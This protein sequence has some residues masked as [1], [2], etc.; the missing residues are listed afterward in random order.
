MPTAAFYTFG[1]RLNQ[2]ETAMMA[3]GLQNIGYKIITDLDTADLCVI[4]TCTVTDQSDAK[5]LQKIRS[6]KRVNSKAVIAVVGC[7]SQISE[8]KIIEQD[9][10]D[11]IIGNQEKLNLAEYVEQFLKNRLPII[12]TGPIS[13]EPFSINLIGQHLQTTRANLKIQDGCDFICSFCIIPKAR[14]RARSREMDNIRQEAMVLANM[15]V[16]EIVLTGV[17][18]GTYH[19]DGNY[20]IDL[21]EIFESIA[22]VERVRISSIEPSTIGP[23]I[24]PWMANKST[25]TLPHL[26]LPLQSTDNEILT[27]MRRKYRFEEYRD[28]IIQA[29]EQVPGICIG[30]DVIVG[31]PGETD[32][33]F[34]ETVT[35]LT[36]IPIHYFHVFPYAERK[37]TTSA[38]M[39]GAVSAETISRRAA[40]LRELSDQ[41]RSAFS[42]T[43]IGQ[44]LEVLFE[45]NN[46]GMVWKGYSENYIRISVNG[47]IPLANKIK[48]V[49]LDYC[50]NGLNMG[51]LV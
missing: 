4:N 20:F 30:S 28:F 31:F 10:V 11:L 32:E 14:G 2:T 35:Q 19:Y 26:H 40:V 42:R 8:E 6:V 45:G 21:L 15:G 48:K 44:E 29:V 38:K 18:I 5:C 25:K 1:C 47:D 36:N 9:G 24:F 41:K 49:R 51:S 3:Q 50:E 12:K 13:K 37:G 17:N 27:A 23:E 7:Y 34:E 39:E 43:F 33:M 16:K 46:D 22:G